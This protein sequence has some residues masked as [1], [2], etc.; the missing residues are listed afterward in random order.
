MLKIFLTGAL[1]FSFCLLGQEL[2]PATEQIRDR[3]L[4]IYKETEG[5]GVDYYDRFMQMLYLLGLIIV[6]L[7][8]AMYFL[9]RFVQGNVERANASSNIKIL[10]QR[11][12]SARSVL[13]IVEAEGKQVL[14]AETASQVTKLAE[15]SPEGRSFRDLM[16]K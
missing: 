15:L 13:Y 8:V 1:L 14:V 7:F 6:G 9:K 12:L 16:D 4:E 10:E 3:G 2:S 11:N 5:G